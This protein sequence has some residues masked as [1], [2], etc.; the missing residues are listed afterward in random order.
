VFVLAACH[1][2]RQPE[3][4]PL[5]FS[6]SDSANIAWLEANGRRTEGQQIV[7]WAPPEQMSGEWQA[8][9]TDS[10][11][12]GVAALRRQ[13]G[14]P[15]SWQRIGTRSIR[16]Y[17]VP[18]RLISH[19]TGKDVVFISMLRVQDG[20]APYLH[21]AVHELLAPE[22]PFFYDE[23]PD[24][25]QAEAVLQ[26][27][28][29]WLEEGLPDVLAQR[30]ASEAGTREGDVFAIGGLERADSTCAAR[31]AQSPYRED[32]LRVIG[33]R[34]Y[35]DALFTTDRIKVAPAFYACA[36]SMAKYLVDV[37]GMARTVDVFPAMKRRDWVGSIERSAGVPLDTLRAR[38]RIR[39][40]VPSP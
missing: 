27:M 40:G 1:V 17:L 26:S 28:P 18:D 3:A 21:E 29:Y 10:V 32:L 8:A 23:Y 34:G 30:A 16:Y 25:T 20:R 38:W 36:Q 15:L 35:I 39:L 4:Q 7:L 31:L 5:D 14:S 33:G 12:R 2:A 19:A 13:I 37:I 11:D 6:A 9:L 24:T 22:A